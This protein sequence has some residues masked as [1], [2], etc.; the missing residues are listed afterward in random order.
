MDIIKNYDSLSEFIFGEGN[1]VLEKCDSGILVKNRSEKY[2]SLAAHADKFLGTHEAYKSRFVL[3]TCK[4][5][6]PIA[7]YH[8][9]TI[10]YIGLEYTIY[11]FGKSQTVTSD[12]FSEI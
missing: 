6:V 1:A 11:E 10:E 4:G 7:A 5:S 3:K 12:D 2:S 8:K 9:I